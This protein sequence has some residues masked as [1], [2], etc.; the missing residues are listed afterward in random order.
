MPK[1]Y[2]VFLGGK[3]GAGKLGEDHEVVLVVAPDVAT[4]RLQAKEKW[5]GV[6]KES[7]HVD[8]IE[9]VSEVDG[10]AILVGPQG[11]ADFSSRNIDD[12]YVPLV[13]CI[14]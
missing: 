11:N 10:Y 12:R 2:V 7:V 8:A 1:L 4:A 6:D 5:N 13:E 3:L 9:E 14:Q